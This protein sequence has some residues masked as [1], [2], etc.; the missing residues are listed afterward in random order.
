[1]CEQQPSM[2]RKLSPEAIKAIMSPPMHIPAPP[3][4]TLQEY[5]GGWEGFAEHIC[6]EQAGETRWLW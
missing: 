2:R 1:M 3:T 4:G 5:Y 6:R